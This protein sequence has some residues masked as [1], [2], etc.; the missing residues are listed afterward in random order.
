MNINFSP[1]LGK[2]I[3]RYSPNNLGYPH[4]V[5]SIVVSRYAS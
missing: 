2:L 4:Q 1:F 3:T 5:N